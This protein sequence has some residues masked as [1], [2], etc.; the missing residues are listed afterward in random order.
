MGW[1]VMEYVPTPSLG[2]AGTMDEVELRG[3]MQQLL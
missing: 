1:L 3:V 2:R